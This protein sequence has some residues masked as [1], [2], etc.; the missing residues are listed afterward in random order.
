MQDF[1]YF[2]PEGHQRHR[3]MGHP[4]RPE[5]IE[6][7][8]Q[9]IKE[10][11]AWDAYPKIQP[12][13]LSLDFIQRVHSPA[14]LTRLKDACRSGEY[15]NPDTYT[16]P[17]S[18]QLAWQAAGG[19]VAVAQSVWTGQSKA[20]L[21]ITRPPGHHATW[22]QGMGFCLLNNAAI[23][24]EFLLTGA[25]TN[26]HPVERLAIIDLDLHHGN[27]IQDIFWQRGDVFYIS[28][29]QS[30]LYPGSGFL[31]EIGAGPGEGANMNIPLPPGTGD[32]GFL[33]VME[34][35]I[36][37][38][39]TVYQPHILFVCLGFDPHWKDP[40]GHLKCSAQGF[41]IL[42]SQLSTW[43]QKNCNGKIAL[44]LEGGYDLEAARACSQAF[45]TTFIQRPWRDFLGPSPRPEGHSWRSVLTQ[46]RQIWKF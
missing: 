30:P 25:E 45:I 24:A 43:A 6:A 18:W 34:E 40:L 4:E 15:V 21:A 12:A 14:Y 39:L 20:G 13:N 17:E 1:V 22:E 27:G 46:A 26:P 9:G 36:I 23:A 5:R 44:F 28:T 10:I 29:H 3:Q 16:Q 37:P 41:H 38:A 35:L 19:A 7:F 2:Y 11:D 8:C 42:L 32:T 33:A 31:H